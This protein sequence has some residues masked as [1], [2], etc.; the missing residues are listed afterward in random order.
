MSTFKNI[1]MKM[2]GGK[3]RTQRVKVLASGKYKFVKNLTKSRVSRNVK[4][5]T[6]RRRLSLTKKRRR[7][8][9]KL[10]IPLAPIARIIAAPAVRAGIANAMVGNVDGVL[11][12]AGKFVGM[13]NG[14]FDMNALISN[15]TPVVVGCLVHKFI[16]GAPLNVNRMLASANVPLLRI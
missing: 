11:Y 6:K 4:S 13:A 3:S 15:I 10:T 9:R 7:G 8:A 12:E 5:K 2:K 14:T 16:G 1:R